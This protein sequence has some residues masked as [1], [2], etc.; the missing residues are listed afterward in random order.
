M[1]KNWFLASSSF[2]IWSIMMKLQK[3]K[4]RSNKNLLISIEILSSEVICPCPGA[5]YMFK[6]MKKN[7]CKIRVQSSPSET[8]SKCSVIIVSCV[9]QNLPHLNYLPL[10]PMYKKRFLASSSFTVWSIMMKLHKNDR[11]NKNS[12][13]T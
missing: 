10:P 1:V 9:A 4:D 7:L 12:L 13:L 5:I 6:I 8:Y 3:K 2:T 11:S